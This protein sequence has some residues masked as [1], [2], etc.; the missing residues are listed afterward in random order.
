MTGQWWN[1]DDQLLAALRRAL[2]EEDVP[3]KVVQQAKDAY[4]WLGVDEELAALA[5]DSDESDRLVGVRTEAAPLRTMIFATERLTIELQVTNDALHGQL[6]PP[7][8][9]EVELDPGGGDRS[10]ASIDPLGAFVLRPI[11]PAPFRLHCRTAEDGSA[12]TTWI[13]LSE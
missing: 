12:M 7:Q 6:I 4:G 13:T 2:R 10:R 9:G 11:P 5:Y 8:S 3:P 1:D